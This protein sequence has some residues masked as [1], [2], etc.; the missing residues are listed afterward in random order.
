MGHGFTV[1]PG[2][3]AAAG[4]EVAALCEQCGHLASDV[5]GALAGMAAAGTPTWRRR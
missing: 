1:R 3:L 5:V 4:A 2:N